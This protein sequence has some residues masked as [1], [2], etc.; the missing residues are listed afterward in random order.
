MLRIVPLLKTFHQTVFFS[1]LNT[2]TQCVNS[3]LSCSSTYLFCL[4]S[5]VS[6]EKCVESLKLSQELQLC[7]K[8]VYVKKN[9]K[10]PSSSFL[11]LLVNTVTLVKH[12]NL[13]HFYTYFHLHTQN[14]QRLACLYYSLWE[15]HYLF[16]FLSG[17]LDDYLE[18]EMDFQQTQNWFGCLFKSI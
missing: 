4:K 8:T 1:I 11:L 7:R 14:K 18:N 10:L 2:R 17:C 13:F 9:C 3:T 5:L 15:I 6:V 12:S 16:V